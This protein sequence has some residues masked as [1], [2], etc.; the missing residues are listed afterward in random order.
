VLEQGGAEEPVRLSSRII[1]GVQSWQRRAEP[2]DDITLIVI[3][4]GG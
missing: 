1:T 4:V 3:E 2:Q